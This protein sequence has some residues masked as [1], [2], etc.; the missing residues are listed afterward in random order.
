MISNNAR[1]YRQNKLRLSHLSIFW[2]FGVLPKSAIHLKNLKQMVMARV[3]MHF[4]SE[5]V[6]S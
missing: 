2:C 6:F 1:N 3:R 5:R 4:Y